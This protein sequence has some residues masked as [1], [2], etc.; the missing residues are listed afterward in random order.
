MNEREQKLK[1]FYY[2][3]INEKLTTNYNYTYIIL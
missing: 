2:L 1:Y 3:K